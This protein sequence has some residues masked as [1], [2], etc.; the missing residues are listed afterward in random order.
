VSRET[1]LSVRR[2]CEVL[3]VNRSTL[4][5]KPSGGRPK[6]A[7]AARDAAVLPVLQEL[8]GRF[9][10]YG[11]RRLKVLVSRQLGCPVNAKRIRRLMQEHDLVTAQ[12]VARAR[13]RPHP[14]QVE[15]T[16]PNQVWQM[17]F[18]KFLV[19][20]TWVWLL[21][22]MDRFSREVVGWTL[23]L[24]ARA[25]EVCA[26]LDT[27]LRDRFPQGVRGQGLKVASDNG[28]AFLSEHFQE[29]AR[30]LEVGLLRTRVR[31]PEG[32]GRCERLIRTIKEEEVWLNEYAT[33]DEARA[34]LTEFLEFY[35]A[36]R[37]HSALGYRSPRQYVAL[38]QAGRLSSDAA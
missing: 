25:T 4:Y 29:F 5:R 31:Y 36:D 24:R 13:P 21:V 14:R 37:I 15:A 11:Y 8:A 19:G 33:M 34:R 18:T 23:S 7:Q 35:N 27:A 6:A 28:S 2:V 20:T 30:L 38:W 1:G 32:N 16:A 3:E 9:P 17:D 22:V 12:R 10:T 26:V